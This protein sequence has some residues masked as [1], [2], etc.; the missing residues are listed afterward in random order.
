GNRNPWEIANCYLLDPQSGE[1]FSTADGSLKIMVGTADPAIWRNQPMS[2][3]KALPR[4]H[5]SRVM[6][7]MGYRY[8]RQQIMDHFKQYFKSMSHIEKGTTPDLF[9]SI[10]PDVPE[11]KQ[12]SHRHQGKVTRGNS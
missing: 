5:P 4:L 3:A 10:K 1:V 8:S 7:F 12:V 11:N 6:N 2:R 9:T